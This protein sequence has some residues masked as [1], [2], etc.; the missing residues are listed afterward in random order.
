[1]AKAKKKSHGISWKQFQAALIKPPCPRKGPRGRKTTAAERE[2]CREIIRPQLQS[3]LE[4]CRLTASQVLLKKASQNDAS[5]SLASA[6]KL[7]STL[8]A[9]LKSSHVA[10]EKC[11][12]AR[13]TTGRLTP[14]VEAV[15]QAAVKKRKRVAAEAKIVAEGVAASSLPAAVK[16]S[17][18]SD[19]KEIELEAAKSMGMSDQD[20]RRN[21]AAFGRPGEGKLFIPV[22]E[23]GRIG[24]EQRRNVAAFGRDAAGNILSGSPAPKR[25][26][27]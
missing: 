6:Q 19:L 1:M 11:R 22:A 14:K 21:V 10:L 24:I 26:K 7:V 8:Q 20:I 12:K 18:V 25:K 3:C 17:V 23:L 15:Q 9:E 5:G 4:R 16:A 13:S 2:L 27:K